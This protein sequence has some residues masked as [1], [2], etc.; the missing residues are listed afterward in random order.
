MHQWSAR[1]AAQLKT[2]DERLQALAQKA[3]LI[4]PFDLM[5]IEGHR[6]IERQQQ[7]FAEGKSRIDGV[8]RLG[9]HNHDPSQAIDMAPLRGGRIDWDDR[10]LWLVFGG[11]VLAAAGALQL[12][13][14]WG[15]DWDGD[16]HFRDQRFHDMPH[17]ELLEG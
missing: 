17:F 15:G 6:S 11:I 2:C 9:K 14:R 7:L 12:P 13:I 16:G 4:S 10:E 8:A 1:S 3:L 5:V